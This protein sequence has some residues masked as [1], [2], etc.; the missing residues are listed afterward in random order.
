MAVWS[1]V[2]VSDLERATRLDAE[3]YQPKYRI[4]FARGLWVGVGNLVEICQ[5]GISQAMTEAALG[6]PIF[7][8]DD[9]KN[10]FLVDDEVKYVQLAPSVFDKYRLELGD[11]LF[12]RVNSEEFVG[13][14]GIVKLLGDYVFASYLIRLRVR[15]DSPVLPDYLNAFLNSALGVKQ[16]RKLSRRAVNQANVNA[17]ELKS[18]RVAVAPLAAQREIKQ[19]CDE[20]FA[21]FTRCKSLYLNA[22]RVVLE[23]MGW[24]K[25]DMSQPKWWAAPLSRARES[26]RFDAEHFQPKYDNLISHL[27]RTGKARP[28]GEVASYIKRGVQPRYVDGGLVLVVNSRHVGKQFI[29]TEQSER[30]DEVFWTGNPR[31]QARRYDVVMNSTGRGTI[32]RTNCV[33]HEDKTVVDN[34]VTIIR[35]K[36]DICNPIYLAVCLNSPLGLMQ[37]DRWLSGSSGQIEIY[38]ADI[39]RYLL[40]LPTAELQQKVANLVLASHKARQKAHALLDEAKQKVEAL[41]EGS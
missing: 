17:E 41:I 8:M 38:P 24:E 20:S 37:T 32:G 9:I 7:R 4:D 11:I 40:Y 33:L 36:E 3:Y 5:Y 31:A 18:I 15:P 29:D 12:N 22:E 19:L 39:A 14:T 35:V 25:L 2:R 1:V 6:Y 23:E 34:H 16:I 26:N 30:T 10:G 21:E 13:R 27:H 28:L